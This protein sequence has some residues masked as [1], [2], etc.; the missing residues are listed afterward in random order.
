MLQLFHLHKFMSQTI[1]KWLAPRK[2]DASIDGAALSD[3]Q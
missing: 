1:L 2:D 3:T